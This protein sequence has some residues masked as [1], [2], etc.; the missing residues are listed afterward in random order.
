MTVATVEPLEVGNIG[1]AKRPFRFGVL[2]RSLESRRSC[3]DMARTAEDLG[4]ATAVV[5]E[6][7]DTPFG[8]FSVATAIATATTSLRVGTLM[9]LNEMRHPAALA[10]EAASLDVLSDGRLELGIG[11]GWKLSD[12]A[13]IGRALPPGRERVDRLRET[14]E[15]VKG[16]FGDEPC[17]LS[18]TRVSL[19]DLDGQP[20]PRQ[21]PHPP[22]VVGGAGRRVM[23]LAAAEAD[24]V[25]I[26]PALGPGPL[27]PRA[28]SMDAARTT[29]DHLARAAGKRMADLELNLLPLRTVV[30]T[31]VR[32]AVSEVAHDYGLADDVVASSPFFLIGSTTGLVERLT[33]L[34]DE[35]GISYVVA[36][37]DVMHA[38]ADVVARLA[39]VTVR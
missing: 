5:G 1:R 2:V 22:F 24:I 17:S 31:N 23:Q 37:Q 8:P 27:S 32:S 12:Y 11:A 9:L 39:T 26:N 36:R 7:L 25:G 4:Y 34:R 10:K 16:L 13:A 21:R 30:T 18:G 33:M 3:L 6:H 29:V 19:V 35:L 28:V 20:K 15:F 38:F 14:I